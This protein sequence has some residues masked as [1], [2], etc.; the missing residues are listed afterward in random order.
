MWLEMIWASLDSIFSGGQGDI[1]TV[2]WQCLWRDREGQE[3]EEEGGWEGERVRVRGW[4]WEGGR[5]MEPQKHS[6]LREILQFLS[7]HHHHPT[8]QG[9]IYNNV[10]LRIEIVPLKQL[11]HDT[12]AILITKNQTYMT[13]SLTTVI[14]SITATPRWVLCLMF[15]IYFQRKY[16]WM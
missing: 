6:V 1:P 11:L 10:L 3:G 16:V 12:L 5:V 14:L 8:N 4:W 15:S 2:V 13:I 9:E 7:A